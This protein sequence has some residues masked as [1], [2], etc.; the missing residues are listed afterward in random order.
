M[1][2][3]I[4]FSILTGIAV[5]FATAQLAYSQVQQQP[6]QQQQQQMPQQPELLD[7][8][9]VSDEELAH[10][11]E[12]SNKL[13]PIQEEVRSEFQT[14]VEE[15]GMEFERFQQILM[16]MQNPQLADQME[17]SADEE[18]SIQVMQPKLMEVQM[19]AEEQMVS[20]IEESG[21]ELERF[22]AI[23]MT[24]QQNP[25]LLERLQELTEE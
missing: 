17:V 21:M 7:P 19:G 2:K 11:V 23:S 4:K 20:E 10:F 18:E 6:Q 1:T 15:E 24:L 22:Q 3:L 25:E 14:I 12:T 5:L 16:A 8:D 13:Q 9:D